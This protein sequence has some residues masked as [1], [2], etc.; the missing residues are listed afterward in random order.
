MSKLIIKYP[1][2]NLGCKRSN[3]YNRIESQQI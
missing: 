3:N 2:N 1:E